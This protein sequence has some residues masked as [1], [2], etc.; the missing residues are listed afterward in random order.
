VAEQSH[1][2]EKVASQA[3]RTGINYIIYSMTTLVSG[4][5]AFRLCGFVDM[6]R[7]LFKI[8]A[9]VFYQR[10]F[11]LLS[12]GLPGRWIWR[13]WLSG[14]ARLADARQPRLLSGARPWR[15]GCRTLLAALVLFLLWHRP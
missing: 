2:P 3:F 4:T 10:Q 5:Q 9:T 8:S 1:Y 6:F 14:R 15:S 11:V 13:S 7:K 12:G